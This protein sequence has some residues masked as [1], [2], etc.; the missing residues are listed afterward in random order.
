MKYTIAIPTYNNAET[1][2]KA[3]ESALNQETELEYDVLVVNNNSSDN[4][5]EK[6][7]SFNDQRLK[8]ITNTKTVDQ[9]ENH[10]VCLRKAQGDYVLF[11]HSDDTLNQNAIEVID[12]HL[13]LYNYPKRIV[14]F[15]RSLFRDFYIGYQNGL[16]PIN[17]MLS[18]VYSLKI[19]E[20]R[21]LTPSGTC[22]S[23]LTFIEGGG[24]LPMTNR[25]TPSDMSSMLLFALR[26]AEFLM[27]DRIIFNRE[28]A[29]TATNLTKK[30]EFESVVDALKE[31]EKKISENQ[32]ERLQDAALNLTDLNL[33]YI[34]AL[35]KAGFKINTKR[36]TQAKIKWIFKDK[37]NLI[38]V[39]YQSFTRKLFFS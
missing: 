12:S 36:L 38:K 20:G 32:K 34:I 30:D 9:F 31:L 19:F 16:T 14:A 23:R 37:K 33:R 21:G 28:Y 1:I 35:K 17:T 26:G 11:C 10:N 15:G 13:K 4:T 7:N 22:Y 3:V 39:I 6:L 29:S 5:I 25:I 8:I 18:G 2:A 24:F 27:F